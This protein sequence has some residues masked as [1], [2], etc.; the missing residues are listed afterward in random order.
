MKYQHYLLSLLVTL[1]FLGLS[2]CSNNKVLKN[3]DPNEI[4]MLGEKCE[5]LHKSHIDAWD[6]RDSENLRLIYSEDIVHFDGRP[7]FVGI[8]QVVDMARAMFIQFP[9]LQMEVGKTYISK[10]ACLGTWTFWGIFGI[11]EN[12]PGLEFDLLETQDGKISF[13]RLYYG[14]NYFDSLNKDMVDDDF[15]LNFA[16]S[17]SSGRSNKIGKLYAQDANLEDS[18]HGI[19]V[20]GNQP[21]K[22]YASGFFAK[23][24]EAKWELVY[25]FAEDDVEWG[26][27][28]QYPFPSQGGIFS[29]TIIDAEGNPCEI[30]AVV[31]LTP[32]EERAI[33]TQKIFYE[34]NTLLTCGWAK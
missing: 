14:Q 20:K 19:S 29:I 3:L 33:Q 9:N 30:R 22:E 12:D 17:W 25:P 21:I 24:P 27:K 23:S 7:I 32:N 10:D 2:S 13:W 11:S 28:E 15:L 26:F 16:S 34:A 31:I 18:L 8:D 5:A 1:F 4:T 6:S